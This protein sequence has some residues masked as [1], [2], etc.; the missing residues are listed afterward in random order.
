MEQGKAE[1]LVD[2]ISV[3]RGPLEPSGHERHFERNESL[4]FIDRDPAVPIEI[5]LARRKCLEDLM[6]EETILNFRGFIGR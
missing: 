4:E 5:G 3:H 1:P 6:S 2:V